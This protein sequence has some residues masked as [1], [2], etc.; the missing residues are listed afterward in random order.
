MDQH[1]V[2]VVQPELLKRPVDR[3]DR[4]VVV[5]DFRGQF[6][7]DEE[8]LAPDAA[9]AHAFADAA[10]VAVSLRVSILR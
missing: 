2:N 10:L 9:G 7:R 4:V 1:Q 8:L 3:G 5:L 6:A